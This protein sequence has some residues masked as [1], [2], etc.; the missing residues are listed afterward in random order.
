M[1]V[2]SVL[3]PIANKYLGPYGCYTMGIVSYILVLLYL[4][5]VVKSVP[6]PIATSLNTNVSLIVTDF[7]NEDQ[8]SISKSEN[9]FLA[10]CENDEEIES[11]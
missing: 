5:Y 4:I 9:D 7:S 11:R 1:L 8:Q 10:I 6:K 2:G 3:S